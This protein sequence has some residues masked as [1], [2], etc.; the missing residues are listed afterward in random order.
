MSV[1][2]V[3]RCLG[4]VSLANQKIVLEKVQA[5]TATTESLIAGTAARL[6]TQG[7]EIQKQASGTQ[8][9]IDVLRTAFA[10]IRSALDDV[11]RYRQEALP[12]MAS[13][14]LEMDRLATEA[15]EQ[16]RKVEHA[17]K[18]AADFPIEIIT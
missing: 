18:A 4:R 16:I 2:H 7:A 15:E 11:S 17:E 14:I 12:K 5:V 13:N 10:D 3:D 6:K 8:I 1:E 9:N